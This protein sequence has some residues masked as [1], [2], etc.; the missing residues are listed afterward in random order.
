AP[1]LGPKNKSE[2][3]AKLAIGDDETIRGT[4]SRTALGA[5]GAGPRR[6]LRRL[7][8]AQRKERLDTLCRGDGG[9]EILSASLP[10]LDELRSPFKIECDATGAEANI[11]EHLDVYPFP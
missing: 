10:G 3:H 8:P 4:W 9:G 11:A 7:D 5:A 2:T 6:E 1:A